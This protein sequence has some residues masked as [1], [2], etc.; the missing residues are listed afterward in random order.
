[1]CSSFA[2]SH[3]QLGISSSV[4]LGGVGNVLAL[5]QLDLRISRRIVVRDSKDCVGTL[6]NVTEIIFRVGIALRDGLVEHSRMSWPTVFA[7]KAAKEF[8]HTLRHSTPF[9]VGGV[10][11]I[12]VNSPYLNSTSPAC[13]ESSNRICS[14]ICQRN[15]VCPVY[16]WT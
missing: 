11:C 1:M 7:G 14:S 15:L 5:L 13:Y 2:E 16:R 3:V 9:S 8:E 4:Y 10:A 6:K 12:F